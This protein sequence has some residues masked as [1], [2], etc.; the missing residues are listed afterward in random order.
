MPTTSP[1]PDSSYRALVAAQRAAGRAVRA[2]HIRADLIRR[3]RDPVAAMAEL[4]LI[5]AAAHGACTSDRLRQAGFSEDQ[6][7][8]LEEPA[9]IRAAARLLEAA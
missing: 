2:R 5:T 4:M 3:R 6:I 9:R 1:P 7:D 8:R